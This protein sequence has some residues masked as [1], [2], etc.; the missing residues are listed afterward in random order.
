M[1]FNFN[2]NKYILTRPRLIPLIAFLLAL[3]ILLSL[4]SWQVKRLKW[5]TG[6]INEKE[7]DKI[8]NPIKMIG[9]N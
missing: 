1:K 3:C 8:V 4:S 6:L 7:Y 2:N 5:K 9:P